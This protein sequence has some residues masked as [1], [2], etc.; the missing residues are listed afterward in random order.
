[1]VCSEK[2]F[3]YSFSLKGVPTS[4]LVYQ[5]FWKNKLEDKLM[6]L[7]YKHSILFQSILSSWYLI[8]VLF[9]S[10]WL[11]SW[12]R[13][14]GFSKSILGWFAI[15]QNWAWWSDN[16][17]T[18]LQEVKEESKKLL[19]ILSIRVLDLAVILVGLVIWGRRLKCMV[20][21]KSE[22]SWLLSYFSKSTLKSPS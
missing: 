2:F 15:T 6:S 4:W 13:W 10:I 11:K 18:I 12:Y 9:I 7:Q 17:V 22:I 20:S 21:K 19:K 3:L 5:F 1:M 8:A 14:C 16:A